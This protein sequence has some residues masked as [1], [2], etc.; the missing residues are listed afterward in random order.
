MNRSRL[1]MIGGSGPRCRPARQLS[2]SS[3]AAGQQASSNEQLVQVVVAATDIQIGSN[4]SDRDVR[5]SHFPQASV[6][7]RLITTRVSQVRGPRRRPAHRQ[8]RFR[9]ARQ[10]R[11]RKCRRRSA[12]HDSAGHARRLRA[13]E[14]RR[15]GRRLCPARH[16]RRRSGHRSSRRRRRTRPPRCSRMS[17]SL[18]WAEAF[19]TA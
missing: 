13:G 4:L 15:L 11:G 8:R 18:R 6:P 12:F 9:F 16:T 5:P 19:W 17:Q 10:A 1:L 3:T 2:A 14:R 7:P